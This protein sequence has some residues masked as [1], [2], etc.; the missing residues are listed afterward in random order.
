MQIK[1]WS[2]NVNGLD[3]PNKRRKL[4]N[5]I[6]RGK[7][8][9]VA[10]QET[11]ICQKH[12]SNLTQKNIGKEFYS[13]ANEKK[14][15]VVIYTSPRL[16]SKLAF[17]DQ[18][19]RMI[20]ISINQNNQI[21]LFCNI[22]A[23]NGA[24]TSFVREL[25]EKIMSQQFDNLIIVGDFNG[26]LDPQLDKSGTQKNRLGNK[27]S[28]LPKQFVNLMEEYDLTDIWRITH[29][30]EKDFTFFSDRHQ[31]WSRIDMVWTSNSLS[32]RVSKIKILPR[33]I[34]DH[35]PIEF[36][37][38][39]R[40]NNFKWKFN[41]NMLKSED[42]I[43]KNREILKE[44]FQ[45][46]TSQETSIQVI[47][48]ASKAVMRG[49]LI[50]QN[51]RKNKLKREKY[52][53]VT[54]QLTKLEAGLKANPSDEKLKQDLN[55]WVTQMDYLETEKI[56]KQ[57]KFVKQYNFQNANKPGRWLSRR[58]RKKKQAQFI[59]EIVSEGKTY[60]KDQDI[61]KQF[62]KFYKKLY[63][64]DKINKESIMSFL[65]RQ[66][67]EKIT[68]QQ[69]ERLNKE[70]SVEEIKKAIRVMDS[71]KA[72]GPDGFSASYYKIMIEEVTPHLHKI[73][74]G[75]LQGQK[76]PD[77]WQK[78]S[79]TMI[80]KEGQDPKDV[81]NYR[82]ISLLNVDY[83]IFANILAG[84]LKNFLSDWIKE[85]QV[86]F[87]PTRQV[88]DNVRTILNVIEYYEKN[89]QEELALLSLDAEKAF[90]NLNWD[91][92]KLLLKE[93]D[94]GYQFTNAIEAIYDQQEAKI[95]INLQDSET[96]K[97]DKGTRQGCPLSPLLF[98]MSLEILLNEIRQD[99][100]LRGLKIK[101]E[102]YKIRAYADDVICIISN[103]LENIINWIEKI[104]EYG[105]LA[106]LKL[107]KRKSMV[108]TKNMSKEKKEELS[109]L[110]GL[111]VVDRIQYLGLII[112]GKNSQLMKN[113][114]E[115]KWKEVKKDL[116]NW[117]HLRLSLLGRISVIKM[118][119]LPKLIYLFQV[120]PIIR[121]LSIFNT[122]HKDISKFIWQ[123][124]KPRIKRIN[125]IDE[126]KGVVLA[127][128]IYDFIMKRRVYVGLKNGR[129]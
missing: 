60:T 79:I 59:T 84:R 127:Y 129:L 10:L 41:E 57:M 128:Q 101:N 27:M 11:H 92:L 18:E 106:G 100:R 13:A 26:V 20:A 3:S 49:H 75:I 44:Y 67:L 99:S 15:G 31:S 56:A 97:I 72:P 118:N 5:Q 110:A 124:K 14:R 46:N 87:L 66:N 77:S 52:D 16:D 116:E 125:L 40:I 73:M 48:D 61:L 113:N 17:K 83:K 37:L 121:N 89:N 43:K 65:N 34:S 29:K 23:P 74:N 109:K 108:L 63:T 114:Y 88:R 103:P 111:Q 119:V 107:N 45:L 8:D 78:T 2:N 91:F 53:K 94:F 102:E 95:T 33:T 96:F 122:W 62:F 42:D 68:E 70:I 82:P 117:K 104:E 38:D 21:T 35:C 71:S 69:R 105:K 39:E 4:F 50:Q 115:Q 47:W 28:Q 81:R 6:K 32:T 76:P 123:N 24:K 22:Y 30:K 112:T 25:R 51:A 85:E 64:K 36:R 55:F 12:V 1:C 19:G 93:L 86:G 126:K 80:K 9:I 90:D 120:L 7:Y 98:I 58:V 54:E